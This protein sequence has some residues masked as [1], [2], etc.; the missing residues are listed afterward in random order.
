MS[1][2]VSV[3]LSGL[4]R[5]LS[6]RSLRRARNVLANNVNIVTSM[7]VQMILI[8]RGCNSLNS[9]LRQSNAKQLADKKI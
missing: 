5:M 6:G 8:A 1:V 2:H 9:P 7:T 4:N 3:D